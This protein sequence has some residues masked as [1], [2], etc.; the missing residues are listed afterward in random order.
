MTRT[1]RKKKSDL[2]LGKRARDHLKRDAIGYLL[3]EDYR[4]YR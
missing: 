4:I 1:Q 2:A 3:K